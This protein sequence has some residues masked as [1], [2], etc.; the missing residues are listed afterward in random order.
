MHLHPRPALLCHAVLC[1]VVLCCAVSH[2]QEREIAALSWISFDEYMAQPFFAK[3]PLPYHTLIN[4][5]KA[6]AE[7]HYSGMQGRVF[8]GT[9]ARPRRD[10]LLWSAAAEG[11][12]GTSPSAVAVLA[13]SSGNGTS[14]VFVCG[15]SSGNGTSA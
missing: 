15:S 14:A 8:E 6:W 9:A 7:G 4:A 1:F 2:L 10:L 13:G 12:D 5:S 11:L 3:M